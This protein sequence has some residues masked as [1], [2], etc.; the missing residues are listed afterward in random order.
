MRQLAVYFNDIKAGV[1]TE[2]FPGQEYTF[3]YHEDYRNSSM[4]PISVTFPKQQK[5][6]ISQF[7]FPFFT[8][9]LP[10]GINK[11]VICNSQRID[12]NDAFSLLVAMDDK[13]FIGAINVRE[14]KND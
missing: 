10:E 9:M 2:K 3:Q 11:K 13:D 14:I 1:L 5:V 7:L 4:P 12:E 6:F 8:N